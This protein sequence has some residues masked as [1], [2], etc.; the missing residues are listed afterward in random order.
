M[1]LE[2]VRKHS[3]D[4][5][6]IICNEI[7]DYDWCQKMLP[8][9]TLKYSR[10]FEQMVPFYDECTK[11]IGHRIHGANLAAVLGIDEV[12]TKKKKDKSQTVTQAGIPLLDFEDIDINLK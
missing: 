1:Q 7:V 3:P 11:I 12:F 8:E 2:F 9:Y 10:F 6:H 4:D 5:I